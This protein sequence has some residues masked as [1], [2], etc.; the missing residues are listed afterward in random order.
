MC[1][2]AP[3]C[4]PPQ[5]THYSGTALIFRQR[6]RMMFSQLERTTSLGAGCVCLGRKP[7]SV[8]QIGSGDALCRSDAGFYY[9]LWLFFGQ[10]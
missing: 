4:E 6:S 5:G 7:F 3:L 2:F 8:C 10:E 9:V 1:W